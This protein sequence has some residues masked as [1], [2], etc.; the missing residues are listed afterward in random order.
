MCSIFHHVLI[1]LKINFLLVSNHYAYPVLFTFDEVK[2]KKRAFRWIQQQE[3]EEMAAH[4]IWQKER[5]KNRRRRR[6]VVPD[7]V[8]LSTIW[9]I[10]HSTQLLLVTASQPGC[11]TFF[12]FVLLQ[13][14]TQLLPLDFTHVFFFFPRLLS[15]FGSNLFTRAAFSLYFY[16]LL[17]TREDFFSLWCSGRWCYIYFNLLLSEWPTC[18]LFIPLNPNLLFFSSLLTS[19]G[20]LDF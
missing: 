11:C 20:L 10:A 17:W 15:L 2:M 5:T 4:H 16:S 12:F 14:S 6:R 18:F 13:P 9:S 3:E 8:V 1:W 7:L 19:L